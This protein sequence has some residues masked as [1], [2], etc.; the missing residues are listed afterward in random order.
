MASTLRTSKRFYR[1]LLVHS[2][3][4]DGKHLKFKFTN[5]KRTY[6]VK[7]ILTRFG[8]SRGNTK[9]RIIIYESQSKTIYL[10]KGRA[11]DI[12]TS[13]RVQ[14]PATPPQNLIRLKRLEK[15]VASPCGQLKKPLSN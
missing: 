4:A 13:V 1:D 9:Y 15:R 8:K 2:V 6:E 3:L 14:I 5:P 12:S 11:G 10:K 7:T